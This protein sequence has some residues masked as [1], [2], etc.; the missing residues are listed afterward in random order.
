M[1]I[2]IEPELEAALRTI[3]QRKGV[4]PEAFAMQAL[5][6]G[7]QKSETLLSPRDDWERRLIAI[8]SDCGVSLPH[9]AL[10]RDGIYA[11]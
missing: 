5:R 11:E 3:A 7:I 4:S 1:V 10:G 6:D 2:S 9:S 8:A